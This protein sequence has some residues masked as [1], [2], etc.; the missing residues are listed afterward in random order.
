MYIPD[1]VTRAM[2]L[3]RDAVGM[4]TPCIYCMISTLLQSNIRP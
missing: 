3:L 2:E 4:V 1:V